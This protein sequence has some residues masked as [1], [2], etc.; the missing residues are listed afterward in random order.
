MFALT[1]PEAGSDAVVS[2]DAGAVCMGMHEGKSIYLVV[3]VNPR[4][5]ALHYAKLRANCTVWLSETATIQHR[6]KKTL[7]SRTVSLHDHEGVVIGELGRSTCS[8]AGEWS[9]TRS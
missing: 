7:A 4:E 8:R 6:T 3:M 2:P 9:N 1:G 5:Q